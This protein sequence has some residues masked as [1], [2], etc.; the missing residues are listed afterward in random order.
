[1]AATFNV[2]I[3]GGI[4]MACSFILIVDIVVFV[5]DIALLWFRI[6]TMGSFA[7]YD[8]LQGKFKLDWN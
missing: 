6:I 1:M 3:L 7:P 2:A 4:E 5:N 8:V